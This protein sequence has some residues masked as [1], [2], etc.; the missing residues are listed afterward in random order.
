MNELTENLFCK[1]KPALL[2]A[3]KAYAKEE[4]GVEIVERKTCKWT[5]YNGYSWTTSCGNGTEGSSNSNNI[6]CPFCGG[7]I[8]EIKE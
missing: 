8:V 5:K 2:E 7:E 1:S 6:Y 4:L 3:L